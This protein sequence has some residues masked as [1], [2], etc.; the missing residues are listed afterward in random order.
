M[1]L[2]FLQTL[3]RLGMQIQDTLIV[4]IITNPDFAEKY[5]KRKSTKKKKKK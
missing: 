5:G 2:F 4:Y 3:P 1:H